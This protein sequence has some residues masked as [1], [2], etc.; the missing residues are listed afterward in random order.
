MDGTVEFPVPST[1]YAMQAQ[2]AETV[3][4]VSANVIA[5][6][7]T[8]PV[9]LD[10]DLVVNDTMLVDKSNNV[11]AIATTNTT[12]LATGVVL[13]VDGIVNA[14]GYQ[15]DD[16]DIESLFSWNKRNDIL[17][18]D[19][20]NVAIGTSNTEY[21]L[22]AE[23]KVALIDDVLA[24]KEMYIGRYYLQ[25]KKWIPAINRLKVIVEKYDETIFIEE[26]LHRLVEIHYYLGLIHIYLKT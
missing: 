8:N 5:G 13:N 18:Y 14:R 3:L 12:D 26:A 4:R 24:S 6:E 10:N 2:V 17:F 1:P 11:V 25:K 9:V 7:F 20:G 21:A 15:I 19:S 22:D 16:Q 23:F